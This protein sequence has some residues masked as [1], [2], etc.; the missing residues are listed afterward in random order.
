M[1]LGDL[2]DD[3]D[4]GTVGIRRVDLT[5]EQRPWKL[6]FG[7]PWDL[8]GCREKPW[9]AAED[10]QVIDRRT[11]TQD[12]SWMAGTTEETTAGES[13]GTCTQ[14]RLDKI[15]KFLSWKITQE[16][17]LRMQDYRRLS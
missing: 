1:N 17:N 4:G 14:I 2:Q 9:R 11:G 16:R 8:A 3:V 6:V 5:R 10:K 15:N 7:E 12:W 13:Q